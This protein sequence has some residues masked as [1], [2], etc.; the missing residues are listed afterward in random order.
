MLL[1]LW[2]ICKDNNKN[3]A[4]LYVKIY[5]LELRWFAFQQR[6]LEPVNADKDTLKTCNPFICQYK[7][8]IINN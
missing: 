1:D 7:S 5:I 2:Y 4:L 8:N 6:I 3:Q